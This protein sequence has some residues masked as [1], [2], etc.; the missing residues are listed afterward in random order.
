MTPTQ[1]KNPQPAPTARLT[2]RHVFVFYAKMLATRESFPAVKEYHAKR[3]RVVAGL[4]DIDLE[5]RDL[6]SPTGLLAWLAGRRENLDAHNPYAGWILG[7]PP[8][9]DRD[10]FHKHR[11]SLLRQAACLRRLY[12]QMGAELLAAAFPKAAGLGVSTERLRQFGLADIP[13]NANQECLDYME[14]QAGKEIAVEDGVP[15]ERTDSLLRAE[16]EHLLQLRSLADAKNRVRRRAIER[17]LATEADA[18]QAIYELEVAAFVEIADGFPA[19]SRV[20]FKPLV[21]PPK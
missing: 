10:I 13:P 3:F 12:D 18:D 1:S 8:S 9:P 7:Q 2:L 14:K 20:D 16:E 15:Q 6:A 17:G 4:F 21:P 11:G 19:L 5:T